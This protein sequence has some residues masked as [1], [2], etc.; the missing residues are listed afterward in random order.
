MKKKQY[1]PNALKYAYDAVQNG[2]SVYKA[3]KNYGIP[4][5]TLRDRT[6]GLV[7]VDGR[8]SNYLFDEGTEKKMVDHI[9]HMASIGYGYSRIDVIYLATDLAMFMGKRK[10]QEDILSNKC[11][12][13]Y[14]IWMRV[15]CKLN[16]VVKP[17]S[18]TSPRSSNVTIIGAGNAIGSAV[19][20][21]YVFPGVKFDRA[22]LLD[23]TLPGSDGQCSKSGWSNSDIFKT[24][25]EKHFLKYVSHDISGTPLLILF[26]GH[27]SHVSLTLQDWAESKNIILFIL[28]P[29]CSHILQP[30]DIGC[31]G[32][33][34]ACYNR[35]AQLFMRKNPG[36]KIT[37]YNIGQMSCSPYQKGLSAQNLTSSFRK[38]GIYPFN[39]KA[40]DTSELAPATIYPTATSDEATESAMN[41]THI[42]Q[43]DGN[44]S[45]Q[46][47]SKA[48]TLT[49]QQ[50]EVSSSAQK[51]H[52]ISSDHDESNS[53]PLLSLVPPEN[54]Y[55]DDIQ[56]YT[57]E[58]IIELNTSNNSSNINTCTVN[59][60]PSGF[61]LKRSVVSV[62]KTEKKRKHF[63][64]TGN[65][66][67]KKNM[68]HLNQSKKKGTFKPPYKKSEP[69]AVEN[70][71]KHQNKAGK[72]TCLGTSGLN[73]DKGGPICLDINS[74]SDSDLTD[75]DD[76][77]TCCV[78]YKKSPSE[79][80]QLA[81]I[82]FVKWAQCDNDNCRHWTHLQ[83]CSA[84]RVL[85]RGDTFFCPHCKEQ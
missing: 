73:K 49:I 41:N 80:R 5:S 61:L 32:P 19:P 59:S 26:D 85:R 62:E 42:S 25:L 79:I 40:V 75:D 1:D 12:T 27:R 69:K 37:R 84:V 11:H 60:S 77:E 7:S 3:A 34:K 4:E 56:I 51:E 23:G 76:G 50:F 53:Q 20:P 15:L 58:P 70:V 72:D 14:S 9:A 36:C 83:F 82:V 48:A 30:L 57:A 35:E 74:L 43:D 45:S 66:G 47:F 71:T 67:K 63:T 33:L 64:I 28:P 21:Y 17:Q 24:Y 52:E 44:T 39:P 10:P 16:I 13:K 31:F 65:L 29:H 54:R 78:C 68:D 6:L 8:C 81:G 18:V 22:L 2:M 46:Q 38:S 55:S